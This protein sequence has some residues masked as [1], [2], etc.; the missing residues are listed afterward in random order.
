LRASSE[1]KKLEPVL[2]VRL[3]GGLSTP[4]SRWLWLVKWAL[5][6]PHFIVLAFLLLGLILST[7][8]AFVALLFTGTYPRRLFDYNVGVLRWVWRVAPPVAG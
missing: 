1:T 6:I 5:L 2:G 3:E 4:L 7:I 8:A